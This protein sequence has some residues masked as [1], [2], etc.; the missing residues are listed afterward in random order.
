[1]LKSLWPSNA[2]WRHIYR[3]ALHQAM[4]CCLTAPSLYLKQRCVI[5][6][7]MLIIHNQLHGCWSKGNSKSKDI[8][9]HYIDFIWF[10]GNHLSSALEGLRNYKSCDATNTNIKFMKFA[11]NHTMPLAHHT[12]STPSASLTRDFISYFR[13]LF[14][15]KKTESDKLHQQAIEAELR[16]EYKKLGALKWV[17][18]CNWSTLNCLYFWYLEISIQT[19]ISRQTFAD[20]SRLDRD[21]RYYTIYLVGF[22]KS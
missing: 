6:N 12:T 5:P 3:A 4:A 20:V 9:E 14:R 18:Y 2:I 19:K 1:M 8:S 17:I 21:R 7:A 11:A 15:L 16:K 13:E 10:T 22:D